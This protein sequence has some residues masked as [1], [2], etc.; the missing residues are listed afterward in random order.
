MKLN[1][2]H[3]VT[4]CLPYTRRTRAPFS[5]CTWLTNLVSKSPVN[6]RFRKLGRIIIDTTIMRGLVGLRL[7]SLPNVLLDTLTLNVVLEPM[8]LF[9]MLLMLVMTKFLG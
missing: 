4:R 2:V 9:I 5:V 3:S 7:T 1:L 6:F 8:K